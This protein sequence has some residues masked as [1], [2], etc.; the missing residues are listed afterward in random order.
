MTY[1]S[2]QRILCSIL[3]LFIFKPAL[4]ATLIGS[5]KDD[6]YANFF[7][8]AKGLLIDNDGVIYLSSEQQGSI[9]RIENKKVTITNIV[10][11][12]FEDT[13]LAGIARLKNN[14]FVIINSDDSQIAITD[15]LFKKI[16][17]FSKSGSD[18]G[19]LDTPASVAVSINNRIYVADKDNNRISVFNTQ[20]LFLY[21]FGDSGPDSTRLNQPTHI[22]LDAIENVYVM[23]SGEQNRM[24]IFN[25][26]GTILTQITAETLKPVFKGTPDFSAMTVDMNGMIYFADENTGTVSVYS[27]FD[28]KILDSIGSFGNSTGQFRYISQ[29]AINNKS[30]LVVVDK[31]NEKLEWF[32]LDKNKFE[33]QV[34]TDVIKYDGQVTVTCLQIYAFDDKQSLCVKPDEAGIVLISNDGQEKGKFSTIG[35]PTHIHV[36]NTHVAIL[37]DNIVSGYSFDNKELFKIGRY[38]SSAGGFDE[39]IFVYAIDGLTYVADKNNNR[40]QVFAKDGLFVKM[41]Q[42]GDEKTAPFETVGQMVVSNEGKL[43]VADS[44]GSGTITVSDVASGERISTISLGTDPYN[45]ERVISLELDEQGRLYIFAVTDANPFS[46]IVL[47]NGLP[48]IRFGSEQDN[49]IRQAFADPTN[50]TVLSTNKNSILINDRESHTLSTYQYHEIPPSAFG[51]KISSNKKNVSLRWSKP[52]SS[53]VANYLVEGAVKQDGPFVKIVATKELSKRF[54]A[55]SVKDYDWFRIVALS[56]YGLKAKPSK[57]KFNEYQQVVRD[58]KLKKYTAVIAKAETL[59]KLSPNNTDLMYLK[60]RSLFLNKEYR[61]AVSAFQPLT[62]I[63]SRKKE[64]LKTQ[65]EALFILQEYLDAKSLIDEVLASQPKDIHP[66]IICTELSLRLS[67]AIGAVTCA[68]DGLDLHSDNVRLRYLL[69]KSYIAA[70]I[71]DEGLMQFETIIKSHADDFDT[72]LLIANDL[73][74]LN[75]YEEA[76]SHF[77]FVVGRQSF[78]NEAKNGK[79]KTLIA[80]GRYDEAKTL[81]IALSGNKNFKAIKADGYFFLGQ[82]AYSQKKYTEAVL[83]LTRASKYNSQSIASWALLAQS[84]IQINQLAKGVKTL[85]Q[86]IKKNPNAFELFETLGQIELE[87][88]HYPDANKALTK[89]VELN[90]TSLNAQKLLAQSLFATRDYGKAATHAA[91]AARINPKDIDVLTLQA[92]VASLQGKVGSAIDYLKTA[93]SIKPSSADLQFRLGKV[94]QDANVFDSS[95]IHLEKATAINPS[96]P[97][98]QVALGNLYL[99]R[100]LFDQAISAYEKAIELEP[101][102]DNRA[103]LNVAFASQKRAL[104]F[105]NNAPQLILQDLNIHHVFSAAYKK[106]LNEPIGEVTLEN[107]GATDYGDLTLS[108]Q[109][110]EYMDFPS[111]QKIPL[112]KGS[113]KQ[114]LNI[115]AIFN[116]KILQVDQDTGVQVEVKLSYLRDGKKDD[117]VLTQAMTIYGKNAMVWNDSSMIGS[118]VTPKDDTLRNFVRAVV[119]KYQPAPGPVNDKLV[120]AMSYFS[121]LNALGT[122]YIVDPNTPYASLRDDQVDYVQ[123]PRETLRLK[124]GDCDDLSVLYSAGL[125]NLGINTALLEVPGHLLMMFDTGLPVKEANLVSRDSTLLAVKNNRIWVPIEATMI[126]NSFSEAWAEG[127][128]KYQKAI[129]ENNLGIISLNTAWTKYKPVTLAKSDYKIALPDEA[130]TQKLVDRENKV[131]LTKSIDRLI[132]PYQAMVQSDPSNI[133]ARMQIA[134]LYSRFGLFTKAGFAYEELLEIAPN[135]VSILNNKGNFLL[136]QNK[137]DEAIKEYFKAESIDGNDAFVKLNL[138]MAYYTKGEVK[139]ASESFSQAVTLNESLKEKYNAFAKLLSN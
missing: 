45:V 52:S 46:V 85:N 6:Q 50:M 118:F 106:Y 1:K 74:D 139:K 41:Y 29:M 96:W 22:A 43:Y 115:K 134:I 49:G 77:S 133:M 122:K 58:F 17:R 19:E 54:S 31:T 20:G 10:P 108:F 61:D 113:S 131:L 4:S 119:N 32:Q 15:T 95:K 27:W 83:R 94:Y 78:S 123:F 80:L 71:A 25:R 103:A 105:K 62:L 30:Q 132:L 88:E 114:T 16:L 102:E 120:T 12:V 112:I 51:L 37:E 129:K 28:N 3:L 137:V 63:E 121:S 81:A 101:S 53:L 110:K 99:K 109:I 90:S 84:Y 68:E 75:M 23:E 33:I 56:S 48:V 70:G 38:G 13:D 59:L 116:N 100:R 104:D 128:R 93:L 73:Y 124:S 136:L 8:D 2:K 14:Q 92:D 87:Q 111:I 18:A 24:T 126:N 97:A 26:Q 39:P 44:N 9:L 107:I 40:I 117:L 55:S 35:D 67:D 65:V 98:P 125:E 60:A 72:R 130:L 69:G 11:S 21:S 5:I 79:A 91:Q 82:I 89:A 34:Q 127:A 135:N 42:G 138:A 86:G 36:G 57:A 66:Y 47:Q 76:L 7:E 64:A